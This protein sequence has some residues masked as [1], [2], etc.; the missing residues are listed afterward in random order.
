ML[1]GTPDF[2]EIK[3][4]TYCG[5]SDASPLTI[6]NC[7]FHEEVR[8]Y[9]RDL[10]ERVGA[11]GADYGIASEHAHSNS[12]LLAK[13]AFCKDGVWHSW[14]DYE[15]FADL[16]AAGEPF[17]ATSYMAPT[18]DWARFTEHAVDGGFDPNETRHASRT[19]KITKTTGG[20]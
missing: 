14:I 4:V 9:A 1:R 12:M 5:K 18:P 11:L 16:I 2:I 13:R 3:G 15:R 20:C 7:P 19:G 6:R 17:T 8:K 10:C